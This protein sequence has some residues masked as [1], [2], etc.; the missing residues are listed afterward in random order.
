MIMN[1]G[2]I[3]ENAES[4]L[5]FNEDMQAEMYKIYSIRTAYRAPGQYCTRLFGSHGRP[6]VDYV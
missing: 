5:K 4:S 6:E 2:I 1:L 3:K